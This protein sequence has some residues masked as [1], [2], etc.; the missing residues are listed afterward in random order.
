MKI[1]QNC[2]IGLVARCDDSGLGIMSLDLFKNFIIEK[3]LVVTGSYENHYERYQEFE[4]S[5]A[6]ICEFGTPMIEEIN[7]FLKDL[8]LVI[9]IETPYNWNVFSKAKER[10]IKTILIPMYEW[11]QPNDEIPAKPDL[12]LCPSSLDYDLMPNPKILLPT[13][14]NRKLIPFRERTEAKTFIFNNGHGGWGG[15][16]SL[17]E[18][19]QALPFI[20]SDIKFKV[21]TQVPFEDAIND[22]RVEMET[23]DIP[24]EKL[25]EEGDIALHLHKFDGLSLPL[26]EA[27]SS[28]MPIISINQKPQNTFLPKEL[29][30]EPEATT[31]I[32]IYRD[33]DFSILSPFKIAEMIDKVANMSSDKIKELSQRSNELA[34]KWSWDNLKP[35]YLKVFNEL[36]QNKK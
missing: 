32:K 3:T 1:E 12:F 2:R 14:I 22:S 24:Y 9:A 23:G 5:E 35:E 15:R 25:W 30:I 27:M 28:G 26:N 21:R 4:N 18:F 16:N 10:G 11:T 33:I 29:L 17:N 13:P 36:C 7:Y 20:K 34:E 31:R 6:I 19:F 8:D